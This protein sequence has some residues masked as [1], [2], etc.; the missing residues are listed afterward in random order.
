MLM[1]S[2]KRPLLLI[3][4]SSLT[5]CAVNQP[6]APAPM[7]RSAASASA[8]VPDSEVAR[9]PKMDLSPEL[10][11]GV[12]A[13]EI[14]AQRGAVASA[15]VTELT[16]AKQTRDPRLAERAAQFALVAGNMDT[17]SEALQLWLQ[18]DPDSLRAREQLIVV[19]LRTGKLTESQRLIDEL[20]ARQPDMASPVFQQLVRMVPGQKDKAAAYAMV[21]T[22]A[23]N[24]PD[25]PEARFALLTAAADSGKTEVVDQELDRLATLA[26]KW[27]LPVAW[28]A[29]R[30]RKDQPLAALALLKKE[31]ARRPEASFEMKMAYPRLLVSQK[32]FVEARAAFERLLPQYPRQP[33]L[34]Y[35]T[36]LLAFELNDLPAAR[37]DLEA[38]LAEHYPDTGFLTYSLGQI[39]EAQGDNAAASRWYLQVPKGSQYMAAQ[40]RQAYL[41]AQAGQ[42]DQ[43]IA[44]LG[45]LGSSAEER[46]Q[47]TLASA[48]IAR[49]AKRYDLAYAMLSDALK[50]SGKRPDLLYERAL[51]SDA[52]Q[53]TAA[54]ERDLRQVLKLQPENQQALNALGYI[55]TTRT[56]RYQEAYG[57][58]NRALRIEPNNAMIIDSM[59]WV[60]F[61]LGRSEESL[62][63]LSRAYSLLP[64]QEVAA[65]YGEVLWSLGRQDEARAL[66]NK[67]LQAA[68]TH[69]ALDETM[70]RLT[71][72]Q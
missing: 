38:A 49:E 55:L 9:Y 63:Y 50:Q 62:Q 8:G 6:P 43:A 28:L 72:Q 48:E 44:R 42:T 2:L 41:E 53:D 66:W 11:F 26:P 56:N 45:R 70:K 10:L 17:A 68:G 13:S 27:D 25:L 71:V 16:L 3:L 1:K 5:A 22:L 67:A 60:L 36:G 52:R 30:L 24:Y 19:T 12:L 7:A 64:D 39:A 59:G 61:K 18:I 51:I 32:Q 40:V 58:I 37:R 33:E 4:L 35:A 20:L 65:H 57:L 47:L 54:A 29:D 23:K 69:P 15:S 14:A 21:D 34:L 31:L 46:L